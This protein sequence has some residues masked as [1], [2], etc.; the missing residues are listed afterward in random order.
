MQKYEAVFEYLH[1]SLV[2]S[3]AIYRNSCEELLSPLSL[4]DSQLFDLLDR[5]DYDCWA[6]PVLDASFR[7]RLGKCYLPF[8]SSVKQLNKKIGLLGR[9]LKLEEDLRVSTDFF[10]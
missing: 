8:K 7:D 3:L 4:P 1:A 2:T 6:D 5:I 9:K 10:V